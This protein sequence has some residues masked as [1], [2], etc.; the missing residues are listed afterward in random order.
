MWYECEITQAVIDYV[1]SDQEIGSAVREGNKL[2]SSKIPYDTV[3]FLEA[4][5]D[6]EKRYHA[7][8]CPFVRKAILDKNRIVP[9][10]WCNCSAG[11]QKFSYEII[12]D[13]ELDITLL[14]SPLKGDLRCRFVIDLGDMELK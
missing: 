4:T 13:R 10:Q 1:K 3:K 8:H 7:C 9:F 14:E 6:A 2:Y 12:F 11:F 5:N